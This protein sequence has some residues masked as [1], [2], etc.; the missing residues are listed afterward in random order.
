VKASD[1]RSSLERM[2]AVNREVAGS[3][4]GIVGVAKCLAGKRK[5]CDLSNGIEVDD[6]SGTIT[7]RLVER[8]PEFLYKLAAPAASVVPAK[9]PL[10]TVRSIPST[11]P[12][13]VASVD[14]DEEIRLVRNDHF[15]VWSSDARPDGFPDELRLHLSK[16]PEARLRAV[17][18]GSADWVSLVVAALSAE[19]QRGVLTRYADR[20]HSD[21]LPG[22]FWW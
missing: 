18:K 7:I 4:R 13:R 12:Y 5:R 15:H 10:R 20:L 19:R 21:P 8:D 22:T 6:G 17:E 11:G 3:Y 2:L 14:P 9:T 16:D 1:F